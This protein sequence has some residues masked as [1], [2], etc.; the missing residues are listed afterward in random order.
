MLGEFT[1]QNQTHS[2][3]NL[4][5]RD[6]RALVVLR[7]ARRFG[8]DAFEY[9]VD[10]GVHDGHRFGRDAGVRMDLLED[11]VDVDGIALLP[12]VLLLLVAAAAGL[13]A[14]GGLLRTFG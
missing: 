12:A 4:A 8:G 9:V 5:G 11:A 1:G 2:R 3:L 7:Q 6:R 14:L 10:E 13:L